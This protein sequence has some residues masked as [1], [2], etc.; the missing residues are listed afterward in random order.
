MDTAVS[1]VASPT[2]F[3]IINLIR[4]GL[5]TLP[6]F[7]WPGMD[8]REPKYLLA[9]GVCLLLGLL[10]LRSGIRPYR[11]PWALAF[12]AFVFL[13]YLLAPSVG[14]LLSGVP[15]PSWILQASWYAVVFFL[16]HVAISHQTFSIPDIHAIIDTAIVA[17]VVSAAYGILQHFGFEQ[18]FTGP[19]MSCAGLGNPAVL[20]SFLAMIVP[21]ALYRRQRIVTVG[22]VLMVFFLDSQVAVGALVVALMFLW[23]THNRESRYFVIGVGLLVVAILV[24]GYFTSPRIH[25][26]VNDN[27]RFA[28]WGQVVTDIQTPLT[29]GGS[30]HSITGLGLG[31]FPYIF[32]AQHPKAG[33]G[34]TFLEAHND[35][36]EILYNTGIVGLALFLLALWTF[37][38]SCFPLD[39]LQAHLLA[40]FVC[41]AVSAGGL[42]VWQNGAIVF[43][44]IVITGLLVQKSPKVE[45]Q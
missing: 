17:G 1:S 22:L 3:S 37:V 19:A 29:P 9:A 25:G 44:T 13:G 2:I 27:G 14:I 30:A 15:A 4:F 24:I 40:S 34:E 33:L 20:A 23:G 38:R 5:L 39:R 18:F 42:F 8:T 36:A 28:V 11:N 43:Y 35:Y 21:L 6:F 7:V 12:L 26:F 10:G 32:H 16:A 31:S 45:V 41:V